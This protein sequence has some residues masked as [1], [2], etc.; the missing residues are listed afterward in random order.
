MNVRLGRGFTA[1]ALGVAIAMTGVPIAAAAAPAATQL[2][3]TATDVTYGQ[4]DL[5]GTRAGANTVKVTN[6]GTATVDFPMLTL[7]SGGYD[8]DVVDQSGMDGCPSGKGTPTVFICQLAPLR[9]GET[10]TL[11]FGWLTRATG[12]DHGYTA[13]LEQAADRDATPV[14][15]SASDVRWQVRFAP[16]TGTFAITASGLRYG[17]VDQWGIRHGSTTVR[18]T[19]RS[20]APVEFPLVTFP[21][22]SGTPAYTVWEP[23]CRSVIRHFDDI[24]CVQAPLAPGQSRSVRFWFYLVGGTED[25]DASVRVDAGAD[26]NGTVVPGTAAG[27]SYPVTS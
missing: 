26:A 17:P 6:N 22:S 24:V 11:S 20:A 4:P 3:A 7:P 9:A 16:L 8:K 13:R 19:N 15:G 10:R 1:A 14:P 12:P 21:A 2:T 25:F 18:I 27:T 23:A 5:N